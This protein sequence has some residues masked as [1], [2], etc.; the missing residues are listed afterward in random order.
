MIKGAP[1]TGKSHMIFH[2]ILPQ[3]VARN[4]KV[5]LVCNSNVAVDALM[6]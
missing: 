6:L 2:G 1:G 5:L 4:E 3:A